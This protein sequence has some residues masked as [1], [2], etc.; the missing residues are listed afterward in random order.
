MLDGAL[1]DERVDA[2]V[3]PFDNGLLL[4]RKKT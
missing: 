1:A 3:V 4:C 2:L